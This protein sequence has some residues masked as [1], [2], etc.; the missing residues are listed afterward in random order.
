MTHG[1][2]TIRN[3]VPD[4]MR[5]ARLV[6]KRLGVETRVEGDAIHVPAQEHFVIEHARG[7]A[8][9][10]VQSQIWPGFPS[11]LTSIATAMAT[12]SEGTVVIH[13]WMFEG[14]LYFADAPSREMRAR[15]ILSDPHR[16]VVIGPSQRYAAEPRSPE[17]RAGTPLPAATVC[18]TRSG[19]VG[20]DRQVD[21]RDKH[22]DRRPCALGAQAVR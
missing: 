17:T 4:H 15:I 6:F 11:D 19:D 14:R 21:P 3:A 13:E 20:G 7:G 1:D 5:M 18:A 22:H 10:R 9:P 8:I 16:A 2:A 12:Q